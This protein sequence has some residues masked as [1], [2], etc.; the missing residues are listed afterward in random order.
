MRARVTLGEDG[1][2]G[3]LD[4][5]DLDIGIL[6]LQIF[7]RAGNGAAGADSGDEDIDLAVGIAPDL[8][9]CV[10]FVDGGVLGVYELTGNEARGNFLRELL[11]LRY[12]ALHALRALGENELGAV[13][14]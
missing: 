7:A 5:D 6:L 1:G 13:G 14:L 11:S 2:V 4:R 3:G 10:S 12:G 8:R 9:A